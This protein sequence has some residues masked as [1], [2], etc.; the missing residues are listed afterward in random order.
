MTNSPLHRAYEA[1]IETMCLPR[2]V[3]DRSRMIDDKKHH[4]QD[5]VIAPH[6]SPIVKRNQKNHGFKLTSV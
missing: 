1:D 4:G 2:G 3:D 5:E 6:L